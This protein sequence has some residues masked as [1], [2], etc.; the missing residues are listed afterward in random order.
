MTLGWSAAQL[1][2]PAH[3]RTAASRCLTERS[4]KA[5]PSQDGSGRRGAQAACRTLGFSTGAQMLS[6]ASL[7]LPGIH[8]TFSTDVLICQGDEATLGDCEFVH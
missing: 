3:G 7:A 2:P 4:S 8:D 6:G 5:S 1:T